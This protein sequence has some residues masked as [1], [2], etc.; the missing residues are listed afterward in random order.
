[1]IDSGET[2]GAQPARVGRYRILGVLGRGAMG[3]VYLG[4]DEAIDR[5]VAIKT[6]HRRLLHGEDGAE[7][8]AR[9]RR[10]VRAAGRC[11]HPNIVTIFEY[12]E[13]DNVPY[14]VMEYVQGRELRDYLKDRQPLPLANT[15]AVIVQVLQALSHAHASGVV[16]RDIKPGNVILL[17]DGQVKVT[18]FGIARLETGIGMTQVGMTV[19]TPGYMAPEQ[20]QGKEADRR[21]DLYACGVVLFELL[22]GARPFT[23]RGASELMYQVLNEP[24]RRATLLNP[25]LPPELDAVLT[26]AL[27]KAPEDRFQ[28]ASAFIAALEGLKLVERESAVDGSTVI[29]VAPVQAPEPPPHTLAGWDPALLAQAEKQ[30]VVYLG[31]V[32]KVLVR[33]ATQQ[34]SS[35]VELVQTLA[36][37]I[38]N[39]PD[40]LLFQRR[41]RGVLGGTATG[42]VTAATSASVMG[43]QMSGSLGSFD[44][45]VLET[46]RR[47]LAVHLG[48]IAKVLVK[49]TAIKARTTRDLYERLA[50]HIPTAAERTAF[51]KRAPADGMG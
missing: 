1:M 38:P 24:P 40:R 13:E 27:A 51:L 8:L 7:W 44:Q 9:F 43:S 45:A 47:D 17:A 33:K 31:P 21:A 2:T 4:Y 19:G 28:E 12:G 32:A 18:D 14:I 11:L 16:H 49:Q 20:F 34:V 42:L 25:R 10:E 36:A 5:Q 3:V 46:A 39:E 22:T 50:E 30:L 37:A 23:G 15:V 29:R 48:P 35:P 6:I 41:M 26:R